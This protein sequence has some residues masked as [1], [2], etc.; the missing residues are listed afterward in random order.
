MSLT[1]DTPI[2]TILQIFMQYRI[3]DISDVGMD[4]QMQQKLKP[5]GQAT[6]L[7]HPLF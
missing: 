3:E 2:F 1:S 4:R 7:Q 6:H 5:V